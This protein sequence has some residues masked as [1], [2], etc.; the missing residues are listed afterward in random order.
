MKHA[1]ILWRKQTLSL[2]GSKVTI[3]NNNFKRHS[4]ELIS[5]E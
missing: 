1:A 4:F 3:P 5:K 2:S